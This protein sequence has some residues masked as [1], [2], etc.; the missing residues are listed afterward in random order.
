MI[1]LGS[2]VSLVRKVINYFGEKKCT[3]DKILATP[4]ITGL[5]QS[6]QSWSSRD[7]YFP[8]NNAIV[9]MNC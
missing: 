4:M 1:T 7:I 8:A 2:E 3:R 6:R 5:C 9:L